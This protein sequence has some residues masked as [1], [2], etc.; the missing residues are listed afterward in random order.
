MKIREI[1]E[2]GKK[3]NIKAG[4]GLKTGDYKFFTSSSDA[5][6]YVNE[7]QF[8][9]PGIIM[10]TGGNATLHYCNE[11]FSVSTDCLVLFPKS[12]VSVK[13]L[14]YYLKGNFHILEAGFKGAGLK[15]TSKKYIDEISLKYIPNKEEQKLIVEILDKLIEIINKKSQQLSVYNQLIKSRFVEMFGK[16]TPSKSIGEIAT[17]Y[18]GAS[19]RP[20][21]KFIT[22]DESGENW[23]KIGDV[24]ENDIY[25]TKTAEK[26]TKI[27]AD[28]SRRVKRGDFILSN[29][30]S[31]GRP[32]ILTIDGCVH[33]GW[34]IIS[35]YQKT[36]EPLFFYYLLRSQDVQTQ[37]DGSAGGTCVR[38]LNIDIVKKV[39]V[40]NPP[41]ELQNKFAEFA[42]QID[43]LKFANYK[44]G[45]KYIFYMWKYEYGSEHYE[46]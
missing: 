4:E 32:Y 41:I 12:K 33:D 14:Y 36:Y 27:G 2:Y 34:L 15:H 29:S 1:C 19:P 6:K 17:I 38:N 16:Y 5:N 20:I 43:K 21:S 35:N 13:Y 42:R 44:T 10:G 31:F 11:P 45:L 8:T 22:T 30:M 3:S 25:I 24:G 23:I 37:F 39:V 40:I 28:K 9:R 46:F 26:I 18:R 7:K